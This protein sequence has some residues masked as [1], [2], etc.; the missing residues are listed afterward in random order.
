MPN[1]NITTEAQTVSATGPVVPTTG[2]DIS[3][4]TGDFTLLA[5][6]SALSASSAVSAA[7]IVIEDTVNAFTASLPV[8]VWDIAG[9][10]T[11]PVNV[12]WRK[13]ELP[14]LR[15][16]V[17]NAKLRVNVVTLSGA[18]PSLTIAAAIAT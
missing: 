4:V 6:V 9:P 3:G 17:A 16:G 15:A 13:Y 5:E 2:L 12:S 1:Q 10:I 8:A 7:R 18:T 14:T 11:A